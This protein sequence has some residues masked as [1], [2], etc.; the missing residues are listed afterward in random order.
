MLLYS[1]LSMLLLCLLLSE[2]RM[3]RW[4]VWKRMRVVLWFV[5][6]VMNSERGKEVREESNWHT[7]F[8]CI[9]FPLLE[10][11][12]VIYRRVRDELWGALVWGHKESNAC[13][14]GMNV[15]VWAKT[16]TRKCDWSSD[17]VCSV[18]V[19]SALLFRNAA[20]YWNVSVW[21]C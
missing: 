9:P 18:V 15:W 21:Q 8:R 6:R 19:W 3:R 2:K 20:P 10:S 17:F 13:S 5:C 4:K 1:L 11:E 12:V 14:E 7:V 16:C